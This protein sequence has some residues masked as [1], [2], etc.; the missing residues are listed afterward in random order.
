[1]IAL[2][3]ILSIFALILILFL[4]PVSIIIEYDECFKLDI[5]YLFLKYHVLPSEEV[6]EEE[7]KEKEEVEKTEEEK[8]NSTLE[9]VKE[10]YKKQGFKN[11]VKIIKGICSI[12]FKSGK[13]LILGVKIKEFDVYVLVSDEN[14]AES[15]IQYG[16]VCSVIYPLM[17]MVREVGKNVRCSI[18][19]NYEEKSTTAKCSIKLQVIPLIVMKEAIKLI[20]QL[21]PYVKLVRPNKKGS[22]K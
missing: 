2:Y 5:K 15:A 7:K 20:K 1:M 13:N 3:I 12:V 21:I 11:F 14:A 16:K 22:S 4:I 10:F 19:L 17:S 9:K 8:P 6:E 18:D